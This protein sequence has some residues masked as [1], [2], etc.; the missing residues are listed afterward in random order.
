MNS[1]ARGLAVLGGITVFCSSLV[2]GLLRDQEPLCALKRAALG[3]G[4]LALAAW[5]MTHIALDVVR[6]GV[7]QAEQ[8]NEPS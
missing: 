2:V 7:R 3:A 4:V 5:A 1:I 6:A 8:G